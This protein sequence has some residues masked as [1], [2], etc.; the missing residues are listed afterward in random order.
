MIDTKRVYE[1]HEDTDG[2]RI[3]IDRLWPRGL[4]KS[5]A[6]VDLWMKEISPSKDLR[7]WFNH[8]PEKWVEFLKRYRAEIDLQPELLDKIRAL[9]SDHG[10]VTILYAAKNEEH[11]NAKALLSY[12]QDPSKA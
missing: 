9:E 6:Y 1:P 7:Q 4:S 2:Y 12:L 11:N 8:E 10:K 5:N 3:L